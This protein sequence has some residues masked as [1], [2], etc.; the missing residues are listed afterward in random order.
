MYKY[1]ITNKLSVH[2]M[3]EDLMTYKSDRF[4]GGNTALTDA[5]FMRVSILLQIRYLEAITYQK[6]KSIYKGINHNVISTFALES[7]NNN[8]NNNNR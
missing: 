3:T 2:Q 8:N 4:P 6:K 5:L 1:V 7:C